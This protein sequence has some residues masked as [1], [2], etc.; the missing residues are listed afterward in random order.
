MGGTPKK[1][2][3]GLFHGKSQ[4]KIW[5]MTGGTPI[6]RKPPYGHEPSSRRISAAFFPERGTTYLKVWTGMESACGPGSCHNETGIMVKLLGG[7][8][9]EFHFCIYW[10]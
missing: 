3:D 5:M 1:S 10:E 7:L 6:S 4:S 9:H 2:L 8:E